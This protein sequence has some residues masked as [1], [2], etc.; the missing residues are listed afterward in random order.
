VR[1]CGVHGAG[2]SPLGPIIYAALPDFV[3]SRNC[4]RGMWRMNCEAV[5]IESDLFI[6]LFY[7]ILVIYLFLYLFFIFI[8]FFFLN[9]FAQL[10]LSLFLS[11]LLLVLT[12]RVHVDGTHT[13]RWHESRHDARNH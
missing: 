3:H 4:Q 1:A 13:V 7:F 2:Q 11:L 9:Y 6:Y 12:D 8:Y 10:I 5:G